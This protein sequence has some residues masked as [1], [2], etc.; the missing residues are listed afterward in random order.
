MDG[1]YAGIVY[2]NCSKAPDGEFV[3]ANSTTIYTDAE[4]VRYDS[5]YD[6]S[7]SPE[8]ANSRS[9]HYN[10]FRFMNGTNDLTAADY[11][12]LVDPGGSLNIL[13]YTRRHI[14]PNKELLMYYG[15]DTHFNIAGQT[16]K[17]R[18]SLNVPT[19]LGKEFPNNNMGDG[20][21]SQANANRS[22][23][24]TKIVRHLRVNADNFA[25]FM[26]K[27]T[28]NMATK[29]TS[30]GPDN[31]Q[32]HGELLQRTW[33]LV[34][35]LAHLLTMQPSTFTSP[36]VT[37]DPDITI[38]VKDSKYGVHLKVPIPNTSI[39][40]Y[41][42]HLPHSNDEHQVMPTIYNTLLTLTDEDKKLMYGSADTVHRQ[43]NNML[44]TIQ[45]TSPN[46]SQRIGCFQGPISKDMSITFFALLQKA[47]SVSIYAACP[48]LTE[49]EY[50]LEYRI[51]QGRIMIALLFYTPTSHREESDKQQAIRELQK[52]CTGRAGEG[53]AIHIIQTVNFHFR[54]SDKG[55]HQNN[56][57]SISPPAVTVISIDN[58]PSVVQVLEDLQGHPTI[59]TSIILC[60]LIYHIT[61]TAT[62]D[63]EYEQ[64][65]TG[66]FIITDEET[67]IELQEQQFELNGTQYSTYYETPPKPK[68]SRPSST[69]QSSRGKG[70]K[71]GPSTQ[72]TVATYAGTKSSPTPAQAWG[73]LNKSTTGELELQ[74]SLKKQV[75][76]MM[77]EVAANTV[78]KQLAPIQ[79]KLDI[80]HSVTEELSQALTSQTER[81]AK[82]ENTVQT[83]AATA[84]KQ[85]VQAKEDMLTSLNNSMLSFKAQNK[86]TNEQQEAILADAMRKNRDDF[87]NL[88]NMIHT[89]INPDQGNETET[90]TTTTTPV[91]EDPAVHMKEA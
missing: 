87:D 7:L 14:I 16:P 33:G 50:L 22:T 65:P 70:Q 12:L 18:P 24:S 69:S 56:Y 77:E 11:I 44:E 28:E 15:P 53:E 41:N 74:G 49:G 91:V 9:A 31:L 67:A 4:L 3:V 61:K 34:T 57:D 27:R 59:G 76:Q 88:S 81:T 55:G 32:R 64:T 48:S 13:C 17:V 68:R 82:I 84:K 54:T 2:F 78:A 52:F 39:T 60:G 20:S 1:S 89:A 85:T 47:I 6:I 83:I 42:P 36:Q 5:G 40:S 38:Q 10:V 19:G 71:G 51:R 86:R 80:Q 30:I 23:P 35:P 58:P 63:R 79:Q 75:I 26:D 90:E 66:I 46:P 43:P 45:P 25:T 8:E 21:T 72:R 37:E 62:T 29:L 73:P